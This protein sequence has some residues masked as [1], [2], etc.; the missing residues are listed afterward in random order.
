MRNF[1]PKKMN[2]FRIDALKQQKGRNQPVRN[3]R[4][5][6]HAYFQALVVADCHESL[7]PEELSA[8]LDGRVP[9]VVFFLRDNFEDDLEI[10]KRYF[11]GKET[12]IPR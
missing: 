4:E 9:D 11:Q 2:L 6:E 1:L 5:W 8:F 7:T 10:V 12:D 3:H